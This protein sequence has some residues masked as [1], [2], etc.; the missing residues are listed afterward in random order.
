MPGMQKIRMTNQRKVILTVLGR[1]KSHPTADEVYREV[2]KRL[3]HIS[4]ATVYRNL[5]LLSAHGMIGKLDHA[6]TQK[7]FDGD[8]D[9]HYHIRCVRC[10]RVEDAPLEPFAGLEYNL[11]D[12][13][14]YKVLGHHLEFVGICPHCSKDGEQP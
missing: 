10:G 2:R 8:T 9:H 3:P 4:L 1:S 13:I 5:E 11:S 14:D 7:R 6:G 12:K